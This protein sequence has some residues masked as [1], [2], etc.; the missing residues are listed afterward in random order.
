[1]LLLYLLE[2]SF[3]HSSRCRVH[4]ILCFYTPH[5][6]EQG[7]REESPPARQDWTG[8]WSAAFSL[9]LYSLSSLSLRNLGLLIC[10]TESMLMQPSNLCTC[11]TGHE[12][13]KKNQKH[14]MKPYIWT[15]P[16]FQ[17]TAVTATGGKHCGHSIL[18]SKNRSPPSLYGWEK[19]SSEM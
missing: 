18:K 10:N 19:R 12:I 16:C 7:G 2:L 1:M 8:V 14:F 6:P 13:K 3:L 15:W 17:D 9:R 11:L 5:F 4:L